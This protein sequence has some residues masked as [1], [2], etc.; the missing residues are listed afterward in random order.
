M[1]DSVDEALQISFQQPNE[2]VQC[3]WLRVYSESLALADCYSSG[4]AG[5]FYEQLKRYYIPP[6]TNGSGK[7]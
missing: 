7:Q 5:R 2:R 1:V 4:C 6:A 3:R